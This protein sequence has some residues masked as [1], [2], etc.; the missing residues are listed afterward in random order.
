MTHEEYSWTS[1]DGLSIFAQTWR[2]S[3]AL[4]AA[5]SLVHGVGDHS[6]RY[7]Y[8]VEAL[9]GAVGPMPVA[10]G[11]QSWPLPSGTA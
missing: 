2:P 6:G 10:P 1:F 9:K 5:I 4:R 7:P 8:L 11:C 3:G